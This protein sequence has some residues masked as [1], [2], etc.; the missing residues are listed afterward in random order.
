MED[1]KKHIQS[2]LNNIEAEL[3]RAKSNKV[4]FIAQ[5]NQLLDMLFLIEIYEKYDISRKNIDKIVILPNTKT[6][7]SEY[8]L[9]EDNDLDDKQYWQELVIEEEKVKLHSNDIIIKKKQQSNLEV[10][11]TTDSAI[12]TQ[13]RGYIS[14]EPIW[15]A[16]LTQYGYVRDANVAQDV[17]GLDI[18]YKGKTSP[19]QTRYDPTSPGRPDPRYSIDT[20]TFESGKPTANGG[21]RDNKQFWQKW[22]KLNP[23]SISKNNRWRIEHGL[24]PTIDNVWIKEFPEHG[25]Y[26]GEILIHHHVDQGK[27]AVPVPASTHV[28][29]GGV[30]HCK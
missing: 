23:S 1:I 4:N 6:D 22:E 8:R 25:G 29:S 15:L 27:Y 24:S 19:Y 7:I 3:K 28:G 9:M 21:L 18:S 26:K 14:Q 16:S 13:I 2:K 30:W 10:F 17:Y 12:T 5:K 11:T 20:T